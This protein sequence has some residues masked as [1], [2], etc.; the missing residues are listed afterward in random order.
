MVLQSSVGN[1]A[2]LEGSMAERYIA[3]ECLIFCSRYFK[4][5]E[6]RLN[7][8]QRNDD[9]E[10]NKEK[11]LFNSGGHIIGAV[12]SVQLDDNSHAQAH[13]YVLLHSDHINPYLE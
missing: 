12:E 10:V 11:Y 3:N 2:Q 8:A 1:R 5:V 6:T 13:R 9:S 7:R 4:G